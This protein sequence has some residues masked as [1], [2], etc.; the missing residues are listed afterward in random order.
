MLLLLDLGYRIPSKESVKNNLLISKN[1]GFFN[2]RKKYYTDKNGNA[3]LWET[4]TFPTQCFNPQN[5]EAAQ[6]KRTNVRLSSQDIEDI[7]ENTDTEN[8]S[9]KGRNRAKKRF[10]D[11][12]MADFDLDIMVT[13]TFSKEIVNRESYGDI[14]DMLSVWLDNRVRRN[15]LKYQLV[16]EYHKD[17]KSIH[18]HGFMNSKALKLCDSGKK[19]KGRKV[20][21]ITDFKFGFTTAVRLDKNRERAAWYCYKYITKDTVRIGGRYVLS[22]GKIR[23]P[24]YVYDN[25]PYDEAEGT[26]I[27]LAQG[28]AY[29]ILSNG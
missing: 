29:K 23:K 13:L 14:I 2:Q 17:G 5:L 15:G 20:Y 19:Q 12:M 4:L 1:E 26:H 18:F 9:Q 8:V 16:P 10:F 21:N 7:I 22:G 27:E 3:V 11:A 25:V 28:L 6:D 24:L